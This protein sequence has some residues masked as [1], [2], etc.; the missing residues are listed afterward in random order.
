MDQMKQVSVIL[1]IIA[2]F[3][4]ASNCFASPQNNDI[5][6]GPNSASS[7]KPASLSDN[8]IAE[9]RG[10]ICKILILKETGGNRYSAS[11]EM[12]KKLAYYAKIKIADPNFDLKLANF[13]NQ[14]GS[15]MICPPLGGSFPKQHVLKRALALNIQG[16]VF[17]DFF[18]KNP[19]DFPI[20]V[21]F[22]EVS[23]Q[24]EKET[25]LDYVDK[26]LATPESEMWF[27]RG[28]IKGVKRVLEKFYNA[29]N[30]KDL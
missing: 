21:N 20:D 23:S 27:N 30:A 5:E 2:V 18:L 12:A 1:S 16:D 19:H 29:K 4:L 24:G 17:G 28:E 22:V 3:F 25:L 6:L 10:E 7:T 11:K 9:M 14:Y 15:N 26:L 8:E 13:W